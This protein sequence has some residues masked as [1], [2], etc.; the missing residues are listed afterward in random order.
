MKKPLAGRAAFY[1]MGQRDRARFGFMSFS[2][3]ALRKK[4]NWPGW[5]YTAY[6]R[7]RNS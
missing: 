3:V 4:Y 2:S 1:A 5:A 7:G 6:V